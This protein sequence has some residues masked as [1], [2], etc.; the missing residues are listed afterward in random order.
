MS[1]SLKNTRRSSLLGFV[2]A[3]ATAFGIVALPSPAFAAGSTYF[4]DNTNAGC[5]D[6]GPGTQDQPFCTIGQGSKAAL[7]GDTVRVTAGTYA[8]DIN[9]G[10]SGTVGNPITFSA[11]PGVTVTGGSATTSHGFTISGRSYITV[12]GFTVSNTAAYGI[13]VFGSSNITL[14]GNHVTGAGLPQQGRNS[15]GIYLNSTT[16]SAVT[17]NTTDHNSDAGILL[18]NNSTGNM[19]SGNTT[20]ANAQ[21]WQRAAPGIDV[22]S[23]PNTVRNNLSYAN[24]DSGLQFY[25][26]AH[27]NLVVGNISYGNGDHG[28]DDLNATNQMIVGNSVYHNVTAGINAEGTSTGVLI[29]NNLSVDNGINSPRT[30]SNIRVDTTSESGSTV[31]YNLV[32]LTAGTVQYTWGQNGYTSLAAFQAATGQAAHGL[33]A[34]PKWRAPASGDFHLTSG[35]PAIDSA[36]SDAPGEPATDY[37]GNPRVDDPA[38]SDTGV[39]VR[40]YDDRGAFE[41]QPSGSPVDNPPTAALTLSPATGTAPLT[42]TADASASTDDHGITSYAFAWGDGATTPAQATPTATHTYPTAGSYTVT[43]TVTDTAGQTNTATQTLTVSPA[44]GGITF[45]GST[46]ATVTGRQATVTIPSTVKSGDTMLL[47]VTVGSSSPTVNKPSGWVQVGNAT[48]GGSQSMSSTVLRRTAAA[49]DLG[50]PL[51]VTLSASANLDLTLVAY[52]GINTSSGGVAAH[53]RKVDSTSKSAHTTPVVR[54]AAAGDWVVSFW[55]D[56]SSTTTAWTAPSAVVS[57]DTS[58]GTGT[59]HVSALVGDSGGPLPASPSYGGLTATTNA[60]GS[61]AIMWTV[62]LVPG[63]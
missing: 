51:T 41:F 9:E 52:S 18:T 32:W 23:G 22:R 45:H 54:L 21:G 31:D 27:D 37:E 2:V 8:E 15:A 7:A 19:V 24:E 14:A 16:G 42:V 55:S 6:T 47:Y 3:L 38:T 35:S 34:D 33:Q 39:G 57:R 12:M 4:V 62:A 58:Y 56:K 30:T 48:V 5:T 1:A 17:N 49:K 20:F 63:P 28:I 43:V 13:Y 44:T 11:A 25:T 36:D 61:S 59:G 60:A 10:R 40:T 29:R 53:S 50:K 46:H 26:G